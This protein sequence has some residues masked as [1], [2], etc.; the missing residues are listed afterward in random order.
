MVEQDES[1]DIMYG[2]GGITYGAPTYEGTGYAAPY[3]ISAPVS[4]VTQSP[5]FSPT[6]S[7]VTTALSGMLPQG[8]LSQYGYGAGTP[9]VAAAPG[10]QAGGADNDTVSLIIIGLVIA[11]AVVGVY[12]Y[13]QK[14]GKR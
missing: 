10:T 4:W 14:K 12:M 13:T 5:V 2:R 11:V 6:L 1:K 7:P 3:G 8:V 9:A